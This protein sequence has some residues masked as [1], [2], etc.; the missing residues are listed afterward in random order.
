ML[1]R[2]V[3]YLFFE[4]I[5]NRRFICVVFSPECVTVRFAVLLHLIYSIYCPTSV[6]KDA[7]GGSRSLRYVSDHLAYMGTVK[8]QWVLDFIGI[9][10]TAVTYLFYWEWHQKCAS[11]SVEHLSMILQWNASG[12][13]GL[14]HRKRS[15]A[16]LRRIYLLCCN[17]DKKDAN[18]K[19]DDGDDTT[20]WYQCDILLGP[21]LHSLTR[22]NDNVSPEWWSVYNHFNDVRVTLN[23]SQHT[24]WCV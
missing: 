8:L 22:W 16:S 7:T 21:E 1:N 11:E 14:M 9:D 5:S 19:S 12:I 15:P 17:D 23:F 13:L 20:L 18:E 10:K 3:E 24:V 4:I 6:N 2:D